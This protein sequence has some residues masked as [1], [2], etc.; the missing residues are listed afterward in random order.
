MKNSIYLV[1]LLFISS[2]K[3]NE[4][5][6]IA[7][8]SPDNHVKIELIG[9]KQMMGD[10]WKCELKVKAYDFQEGALIFEIYADDLNDKNVKFDWE[11]EEHCI[12]S[13]T[14]SDTE[15]RHFQLIANKNQ[16]QL[17]EV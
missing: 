8:N 12:I 6:I 11:D 4:E 10:P 14:Q 16:V 15:V 17:A 1:L 3:L 13:I 5:K 9:K 7:N 2:C